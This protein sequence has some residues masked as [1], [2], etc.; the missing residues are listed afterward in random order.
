MCISDK[1]MFSYSFCSFPH[2]SS[3]SFLLIFKCHRLSLLYANPSF[4]L[5]SNSKSTY[6]VRASTT[7]NACC[8]CVSVLYFSL[9]NNIYISYTTSPT[10]RFPNTI[11]PKLFQCPGGDSRVELCWLGIKFFS[12]RRCYKASSRIPGGRELITSSLFPLQPPP[13]LPF[14]P[15]PPEPLPYQP[16]FVHQ[17]PLVIPCTGGSCVRPTIILALTSCRSVYLLNPPHL[18]GLFYYP[19]SCSRSTRRFAMGRSSASSIPRAGSSFPPSFT[20]PATAACA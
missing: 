6:H 4:S 11:K 9:Q 5:D 2:N 12:T 8:T 14:P 3:S 18:E 7:E 13:T 19:P 16:F 1:G 20:C 17:N 15:P 10:I